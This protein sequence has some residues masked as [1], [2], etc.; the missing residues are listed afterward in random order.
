MWA[1]LLSLIIICCT[2]IK[3]LRCYEK[4]E[5]IWNNVPLHAPQCR[6]Q[7]HWENH[8]N[9]GTPKVDTV[10]HKTIATALELQAFIRACA[11]YLVLPCVKKGFLCHYLLM[12]GI[13]DLLYD[14][15]DHVFFV[16]PTFEHLSEKIIKLSLTHWKRRHLT[17]L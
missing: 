17:V 16:V 6:E 12:F 3:R 8:I 9:W 14:F 13:A 15:Y 11:F 4:F 10:R 5:K 1:K 2:V 7:L